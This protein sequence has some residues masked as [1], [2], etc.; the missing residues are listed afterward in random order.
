M[1]LRLIVTGGKAVLQA[2]DDG[3]WKPAGIKDANGLK[4]GVYILDRAIAAD[5]GKA[6]EGQILAIHKDTVYQ[7][8]GKVIVR[9]H[10]KFFPQLPG[11]GEWG[12][13]DYYKEKPVVA[14]TAA[15]S[16]QKTAAVEKKARKLA[17]SY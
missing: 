2:E 5:V 17:R 7:Q 9:H 4:P 16:A 14:I 8:A 13:I 15:T 1:L 6:Y 11:V 3:R 10:A 12:R